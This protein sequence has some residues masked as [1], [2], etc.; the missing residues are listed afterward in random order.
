MIWKLNC[1]HEAFT[2]I[3][4]FFF[5]FSMNLHKRS[6]RAQ[7]SYRFQSP[8]IGGQ[9]TWAQGISSSCN[10]CHLRIK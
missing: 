6:Q 8:G 9:D 1:W 10:I 5:D 4:D 7:N 3:S 2:L